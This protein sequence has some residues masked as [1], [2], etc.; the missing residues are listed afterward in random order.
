MRISRVVTKTGDGGTTALIGGA[1]VP[2]SSPRVQSYGEVD[3]LNSWLG[4]AVALGLDPPLAQQ[5]ERVQHRLFTV[6]ADLAAPSGV[7]VP[8]VDKTH[9]RE[10]EEILRELLAECPPLEEFVLPGGAPAGACLHLAR[11]VCRRAERAVV[12]LAEHEEVNPQVVV[13]LNRLSDLLFVMAR[14]ANRRAGASETLADFSRR[15][16]GADTTRRRKGGP[17]EQGCCS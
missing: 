7:E 14:V 3:E 16:K 2:K 17:Q 12:A 4:L 9:V 11:A 13:Y 6:G 15:R 8:R 1:R 10:L 5:V